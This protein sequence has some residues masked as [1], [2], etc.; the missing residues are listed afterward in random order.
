MDIQEYKKFLMN[1]YLIPSRQI[2]HEHI[3]ENFKVFEKC[4]FK[5]LFDLK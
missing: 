2:L 5:N 3:D 1:Q 4:G